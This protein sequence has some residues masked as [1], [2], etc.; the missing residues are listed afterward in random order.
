MR[1]LNVALTGQG[2]PARLAG[3]LVSADYFDVFG[4]KPALGRT[5]LPDE[6]QAGREPGGRAEPCGLAR[7]ASAEIPAILNR[8]I[9]LDGEPHQVIG[10]S[11]GRQLRSR[12]RRLL[13]AD[14]LRAGAAHTRLSLARRR[15]PAPARR[16]RWTRRGEEMRAVSASLSTL[17]PAFKRN[18]SVD[19][20]SVR[21]G[22]R[23]RQPPPVDLRRVRRGDHG[24]A[25]RLRE[26][27]EPAPGQGRGAPQGNGRPRRARC[28]AR[29]PGRAGADRKPGA[30]RCSGGLAGVGLAYLLICKP[31]C[32]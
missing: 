2:E 19:G 24:A 8:D 14:R 32:R 15:R 12:G 13:E 4:V 28:D 18:W 10:D 29:P 27:R 11:A 1:G 16:Q 25:D 22:S 30:L 5:F 31:P 6:D 17:Q 9:M 26:H 20:R 21:S 23:Q 7:R 3:T